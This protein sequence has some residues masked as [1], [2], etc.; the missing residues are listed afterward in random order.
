MFLGPQND[1]RNLRGFVLSSPMDPHRMGKMS[2]CWS[3]SEWSST[4]KTIVFSKGLFHQ[5]FQGP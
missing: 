3:F 1:A 5:Q 4:E 2:F